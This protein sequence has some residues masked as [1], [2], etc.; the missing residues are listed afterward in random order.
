MDSCNRVI[1]ITG[2]A[3]LFYNQKQKKEV[4]KDFASHVSQE[5]NLK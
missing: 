2:N 5:R 4:I 3:C 1:A